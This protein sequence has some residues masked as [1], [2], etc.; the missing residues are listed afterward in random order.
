[1]QSPLRECPH[2]SD[3]YRTTQGAS[4]KNCALHTLTHITFILTL[5]RK[6][7]NISLL[8]RGASRGTERSSNR[9][10]SHS[11]WSWDWS[12]GSGLKPQLL[13]VWMPLPLYSSTSSVLFNLS[14]QNN[15][16]LYRHPHVCGCG[17][18][19]LWGQPADSGSPLL[20]TGPLALWWWIYPVSVPPGDT[21]GGRWVH[22]GVNHR[23]S[24]T[25]TTQHLQG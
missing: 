3:S 12:P 9:S 10:R 2:K 14:D 19:T 13:A 23:G 18:R 20:L 24:T 16:A 6:K 8:H 17:E 11:K 15:L 4:I 22:W 25:S 5:W 1:M 7:R 21:S